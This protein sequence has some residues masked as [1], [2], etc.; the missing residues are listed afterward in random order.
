MDISIKR[1]KNYSLELADSLNNLLKQ[2]D[3]TADILTKKDVKDIIS[4]P[5]N[6]LF[7]A[8]SADNKKI[9]GMLTLIVFRIPFARKGLVED[10]VIDEKYRRKGI[11][12]KL[13]TAA[14]NQARKEGIKHLEL[15]SR[16]EK[17]AANKLYQ[18]FGFKKRKTNAYRLIL[19]YGEI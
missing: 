2:L 5:A 3:N 16:P 1:V 17:V 19:D 7:V 12:T 14:V 15:T 8:R 4:S 18:R 9:I 6:H 13:V 11:G 10:V